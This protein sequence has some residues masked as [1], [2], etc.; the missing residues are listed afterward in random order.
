[1]KNS[2]SVGFVSANRPGPNRSHDEN[3]GISHLDAPLSFNPEGA[4]P[5]YFYRNPGNE[6]LLMVI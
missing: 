1:M 2:H 6:S 3:S 5:E 4:I